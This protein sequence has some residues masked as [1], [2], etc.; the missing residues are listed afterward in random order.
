MINGYDWQLD[1]HYRENGT[2]KNYYS[3]NIDTKK[4]TV[5]SYFSDTTLYTNGSGSITI[6]GIV[7][8][9]FAGLESLTVEVNEKTI[10]SS[11]VTIKKADEENLKNIL[12][13][14]TISGLGP[15]KWY[16]MATIQGDEITNNNSITKGNITINVNNH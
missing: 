10:T 9:E 3:I 6:D 12:K 4:P 5:T 11:N 14:T 15:N 7:E 1:F 16:W 8:D 13:D 2:G